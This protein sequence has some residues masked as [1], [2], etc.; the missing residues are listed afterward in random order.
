MIVPHLGRADFP[1][2]IAQTMHPRRLHHGLCRSS[3][4]RGSAPTHGR[5]D[6]SEGLIQAE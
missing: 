5:S 3:I 2:N 4:I 1:H 6:L